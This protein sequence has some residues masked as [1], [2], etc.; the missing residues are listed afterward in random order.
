MAQRK[1]ILL[2]GATGLLGSELLEQLKRGE[3]DV[4][5]PTR[6]ELNLADTEAVERYI[7]GIAPEVV[8][9]AA[10][11]INVDALE[12]DPA[13]GRQTNALLPEIIARTLAAHHAHA[14]LVH[15]ST[16][17]V[18][19]G[20]KPFYREDDPPSPIN[21]YGETK[22]EGEELLQQSAKSLRYYIVR[23]SWIYANKRP[24]FVDEVARTLREGKPFQAVDDQYGN[25]TSATDFARAIVLHFVEAEPAR[26]IYH[27]INNTPEQGV[28][29]YEIAQEVAHIVGA[30]ETLVEKAASG[31]V[32]S[33]HRP[34]A[35]LVN[36]KLPALRGWREALQEH[37]GPRV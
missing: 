13:S 2:F 34:S 10:A 36:T 35:V 30:P 37:L 25:P 17:Y 4:A 32:F 14:A 33:A 3:Y 27:C 11:L 19:D 1:H 20:S 21:V 15:I 18:F 12:K 24:T 23:T 31:N 26:G 6:T 16:Q 5:A 28:S 29:R 7:Q 8:I 9:N 22:A